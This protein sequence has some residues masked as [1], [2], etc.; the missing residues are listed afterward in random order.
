MSN[1]SWS[2]HC[3]SIRW[4]SS[5]ADLNSTSIACLLP[6]THLCHIFFSNFRSEAEWS[7]PTCISSWYVCFEDI[8]K[9]EKEREGG[10]ACWV[11]VSEWWEREGGIEGEKGGEKR[12]IKWCNTTGAGL[13]HLPSLL[14]EWASLHQHSSPHSHQTQRPVRKTINS[15]LLLVHTSVKVSYYRK[16]CGFNGMTTYLKFC[17]QAC[18]TACGF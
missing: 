17:L 12:E 18:G 5:S 1:V 7:E 8:D 4:H 11:G 3:M 16:N 2:R 13:T 14:C 10:E 15:S 6:P 9:R